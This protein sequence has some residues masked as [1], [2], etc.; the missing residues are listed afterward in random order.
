MIYCLIAS[1]FLAKP[2]H[3]KRAP[4]FPS[5]GTDAARATAGT[6]I[7]IIIIILFFFIINMV[8]ATRT[9]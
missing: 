7:F 9:R 3:G 8:G 2:T 4:A 6:V 5:G 1:A